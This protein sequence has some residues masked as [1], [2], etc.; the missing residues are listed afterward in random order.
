MAAP[1]GILFSEPQL[2]PLSSAGKVQP[3]CVRKFYFSQSTTTAPVYRDG[4]QLV[5]FTSSPVADGNGRFPPIYLDP[6]ITYRSQL[7]SAG[8]QLLGD[9]DP[10]VSP[11]PF[12]YAKV[13]QVATNVVSNTTAVADPELQITIPGPGTYV[14][15]A[16]L[17]FIT[18]GA[19]GAVPGV[20]VTPV[21][22]GAMQSLAKSTANSS[23]SIIGNMNATSVD[24]FGSLNGSGAGAAGLSAVAYSLAG[25]SALNTLMFNGIFQATEAGVLS[26]NWAQQT[27]NATATTLNRGSYLRY[28]GF[29]L[30]SDTSK[31]TGRPAVINPNTIQNPSSATP[32]VFLAT[33]SLPNVHYVYSRD[34][35]NWLVGTFSGGNAASGGP[36]YGGAVTPLWVQPP[37]NTTRIIQT[38]LDGLSWTVHAAALPN[39]NNWASVA[40]SPTLNL[41]AAVSTNGAINTQIATS[42]D[43]ITW[44]LRTGGTNNAIGWSNII[45][46]A[47]AQKFIAGSASGNSTT[48]TLVSSDGITWTVKT[49]AVAAAAAQ[50][51]DLGGSFDL[52]AESTGITTFAISADN[53]VTWSRAVNPAF[54]QGGNTR[55]PAIPIGGTVYAI[56]VAN[57]GQLMKTTAVDLQSG[58]ANVGAAFGFSCTSLSGAAAAFSPSLNLWAITFGLSGNVSML[59]TSN[60]TTYN[61]ITGISAI[62]DVLAYIAASG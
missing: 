33:F 24:N 17:E 15:D 25:A 12:Q 8:G 34:G 3:G 1:V 30:G 51:R 50:P 35:V 53:G 26:I 21:F 5:A 36:A 20:V 55:G 19:S 61:R 29:G 9:E 14:F 60:G 32:V 38:S 40:W 44:T 42:P 57:P 43:G 39:T 52:V 54:P 58:W 41:F 62:A 56:T 47:T 6:T 13:K 28:V 16:V 18:A 59:T 11:P 48:V 2:A 7:F 37:N 10:Y 31:G 23:F 22:S 27:S 49:S 4:A 46:S 45:W